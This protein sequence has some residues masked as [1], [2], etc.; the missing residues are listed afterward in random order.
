MG[1]CVSPVISQRG[2]LVFLRKPAGVPVFPPHGQPEGAS[3]LQR[4]LTVRPDQASLPWP[5]GFEGGIAHRLDTATSGIVVACTSLAAFAALRASFA[6]GTL[7]KHYRFVS[8]REVPWS[9]H[10]V[11]L[12]IA[13]DRRRRS[14]MV[15]QRGHSTPHRGRWYPAHTE[16]E[17]LGGGRW[18]AVITTG[19]MHQIRAHAAFVGLPLAGDGLYGGGDLPAELSPPPGASFLLH[20][21]HIEGPGWTGPT[22]APPDWWG[23]YGSSS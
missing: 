17:Q 21:E 20:H 16:L 9:H 12:P 23:A 18:R 4:W 1:M 22:E 3:L 2:E 6:E 10:T 7:R 15:V 8:T 11:V 14:R 13:H 5:P 19:V